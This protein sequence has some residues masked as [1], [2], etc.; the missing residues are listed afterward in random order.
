[1]G[2]RNR[3]VVVDLLLRSGQF[4]A[5]LRRASHDMVSETTN[6][7]TK[8]RALQG[9][10]ALLGVAM[11][12]AAAV[13]VVQWAKFDQA[14]S[15][16]EATG[17]SAAKQIADLTEAAK[18]DDVIELG[19]SA[20]EAADAIYELVKAGVDAED[21]IAGGM[22]G[23]M[24]LAAA[25]TMDAAESAAIMA[26]ALTQF[27]LE[28]SESAHVADLL[29]A[30]AG[31]AQ[32]SAHDLGFALKQSGLVANQFGLSIEETTGTLALFASAGLIGSD[33]GT[34]LR[35]MLLHLA[36]PSTKAAELMDEIGLEVYG[37]N[38]HMV[39][40]ATLAD[41]LQSSMGKL[42]E[43]QRN[44]AL[45]T[46]FGADATRAASLLYREGGDAVEEWIAKVD[47]AGYAQ[48]VAR[49]RLDNLAGD[50]KK[51]SA[52]WERSMVNMGESSDGAM[53]SLVQR[54][55][56]VVDW[57]GELDPAIQGV[58]MA[59]TGG[60]GLVIL[61]VLGI[62]Q[63]VSALSTLQAGLVATGVVTQA[64]ATKM[65]TA[66]GK[67]TK[68]LGVVGIA[69]GIAVGIFAAAEA[70]QNRLK[71]STDD[72]AD[73]YDAATGKFTE[74]AK[75][76]ATDQIF[77][78]FGWWERQTGYFDNVAEAAE[79]LGVPLGDLTDAMLGNEQAALRVQAAIEAA[80]SNP[81][82]A[83]S[84][85]PNGQ[86]VSPEA[87]L[88]A[89]E[90]AA[91]VN[92]TIRDNVKV[93]GEAA[94]K[95]EKM[96]QAQ[97]GQVGQ[98]DSLTA[99]IEGLNTEMET[100]VG[101]TEAVTAAEVEAQRA[102]EKYIS[103]IVDSFTSF[104]TLGDVYRGVIASQ[105]D[106]AQSTAEATESSSDSWEDYYDGQTVSADQYI[107]EL[108][109][110]VEAQEQWAQ[111]LLTLT[112]RVGETMP[113]DLRAAA[114]EMI[115]ELRGLGP[116]GAAQIA[117]LESMSDA[118]LQQVVELYR[119]Q[120]I[121]TGEEWAAGVEA[122]E[123]P[124][125]DVDT[126][127]AELKM[128]WLTGEL[129]SLSGT[130]TVIPFKANTDPALTKIEMLKAA[131]RI[132]DVVITADL[133]T[134]NGYYTNRATGG[135]I[136][137]PGTGTSD[138]ILARLSNGE[139]VLTASDVQ[140]AGG[141]AGVYRMRAAIQAGML[142]FANGGAV[143][144]R[145]KTWDYWDNARLD[146]GEILSL[147]IR[148]RDL[149]TDLA[150][151][152]KSRLSGLDRSKAEYDL[153]EA[154]R[155]LEEGL[156]ANSLDQQ[157]SI[158]SRISEYEA[159]QE[160]VQADADR[161]ERLAGRTADYAQDIQRGEFAD[162][163]TSGLSSAFTAIDRLR[164]SV[165]PDLVGVQKTA[166]ADALQAA[167]EQA[168][169]LYAS[170]DDVDG[171]LESATDQAKELQTISDSASAGLV[172][173]FNLKDSVNATKVA[174]V[175]PFTG[176]VTG[177]GAASSGLGM[178][179]SAQAY[180]AK[181]KTLSGKLKSLADRGFTG[182]ILQEI[183]AMGVDAGIPAADA[184][185]TL[186][187]SDTSALNQAYEDI[188][189]FAGQTGQAVTE[190]FYEGGLA[191]ADG[192]V[193]G[194]ADRR[195]DIQQ[196][197][198]DMALDMQDALKKALGIA[199]PSRKFRAMMKFV[200][201]GVVL[202]LDDQSG[203][204]ADASARLFDGVRVPGGASGYGSS[205]SGF[206]GAGDITASLSDAQV[207]RLAVAFE[208]GNVRNINAATAQQNQRVAAVYG[209]RGR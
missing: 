39:D 168:T 106:W 187:P 112:S 53:R 127:P 201:D 156:Y 46:I 137:G 38:G 70:Q 54:L 66:L 16:V 33:A 78:N 160:A 208:T 11:V 166:L 167:E 37:A 72:L 81:D 1:M 119:R 172:N 117:L 135:A 47:D 165:L 12:G 189:T 114:L 13:A 19:Y 198:T 56:E 186:D 107:A 88:R 192:V 170:L 28:G 108:Q 89:Q 45:A 2:T 191:A 147:Q 40:M 80:Y 161:R 77:K 22:A 197:I 122:A 24:A 177:G 83:K 51:L 30:A 58:I 111:N 125:V 99:E 14:M 196:A 97:E 36:G 62:G 176:A 143:G 138:S 178:L 158:E 74:S 42:S 32:G 63:I 209:A 130:D 175:N 169:A 35:T 26:S 59:I 52:T 180:A 200:G 57:F 204:V 150:V 104:S 159:Q 133:R 182:V 48:D 123:N 118:E 93:S 148:S 71:M 61:S 131:L 162:D 27:N 205:G 183:A 64:T 68:A 124:E 76:I 23:A 100:L 154:Q 105:K 163:L 146:Q 84:Q 79:E 90:A 91:L 188:R 25:E 120:G 41:N 206:G 207:E 82:L 34:S 98:A 153:Q 94:V 132:P 202:G 17:G 203:A 18:S 113:A 4:T 141:Q 126:G 43:E 20:T 129:E 184:L 144:P 3:T 134:T 190:G 194:L 85:L 173:G 8:T 95:A 151:R 136:V 9:Q 6:M 29:V 157:K 21:I 128:N 181:V 155:E 96:A 139:H 164:D 199:S 179:Q 44:Q 103:A 49:K 31:K 75:A 185:L 171:V 142:Q 55:T 110:Q 73:A 174:A 60:G 152:G 109:K 195:E 116:E 115:E 7:E 69:L 15:R 102:H 193:A 10:F 121:A 5:G 101:G 140:K 86:W 92:Q 67:V 65:A 149:T 145:G 50:I 87:L